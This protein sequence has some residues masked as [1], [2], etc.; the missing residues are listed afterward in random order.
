MSHRPEPA[1]VL[2]TVDTLSH[3][4][5]DNGSGILRHRDG[6]RRHRGHQ[7]ETPPPLVLAW[8]PGPARTPPGRNHPVENVTRDWA[9]SLTRRNH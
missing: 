3:S 6:L 5:L 7:Q 4:P 1:A 9:V 8:P 2:N